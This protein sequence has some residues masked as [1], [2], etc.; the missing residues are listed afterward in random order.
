ME[1]LPTPGDVTFTS[2]YLNCS[3]GTITEGCSVTSSL[4]RGLGLGWDACLPRCGVD[5][6]L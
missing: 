6:I 1:T 5:D 3:F 4:L 2:P